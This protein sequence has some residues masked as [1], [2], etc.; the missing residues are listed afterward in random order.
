[1]SATGASAREIWEFLGAEGTAPHAGERL[2][3]VSGLGEAGADSVVFAVGEEACRKAL[4]SAAGLIL[5]KREAEADGRVVRVGDPRR[6]FAEVYAR[7]FAEPVVAGVDASAVVGAGVTMGAGC[8]VD[9]GAVIED[10]VVM[11]QGCRIGARVVVHAGTTL[12]DRVRVQAGAVL[13]AYGFG[14]VR[15]EDGY[16]L[17]PQIGTLRVG[18]DVEIGANA[19]IDRGALGETVIG[20]GT[21]IDNLV[22]VGHNCRIGEDVILAAQTGIAGSTEVGDG[23]IVGG[24][25][26]LAEH[27]KVGPGVILGAQ[28]GVPTGKRIEGAGQVFW[29]TPA[30]PI[31]GYLRDLAAL[32]RLRKR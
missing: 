1:M 21:K 24:Q 13:G 18:D 3:R 29:G 20:R 27:V 10:G 16:L 7:F 25:V 11:G 17:F 2:M 32:A 9:A 12:G 5:A 19:T 23:A 31:Q 30:R 8:R 26:G 22:H 4:E 14:Y 15:R 28:A 6:A